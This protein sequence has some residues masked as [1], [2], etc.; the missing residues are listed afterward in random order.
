MSFSKKQLNKNPKD[1]SS[2]TPAHV[3]AIFIQKCNERYENGN[4]IITDYVYDQMFQVFKEKNPEH[5]LLKKI[6]AEPEHDKVTL[7]IHMGSMDKKLNKKS[8]DLW[9]QKYPGPEYIVSSKLDG[10]SGLLV[11]S[12]SKINLYSRGNGTIGRN[13]N[14]LIPYFN[15]PRVPK[16]YIIRGELI[17]SKSDKLDSYTN[18]RSMATA[19]MGK[20]NPGEEAK[21]IKFVCY[22]L[23]SYEG[24]FLKVNIEGQ[25]KVLTRLGFDVVKHKKIDNII[26]PE[27]MEDSTLSKM[28]MEYRLETEYDIDGIIITENKIHS[29]NTS[30]NPDY[31]FAFKSNGMGE[32]TTVKNVDWNISKHGYLIPRINVEQVTIDGTKIQFATAFNAKYVYTNKIGPET[33]V[34]IIRSGDVIPYVIEIIESTHAQMPDIEYSWTKSGVNAIAIGESKELTLKKITSFIKTLGIPFLSKGLIKKLY[35][36]GI[37]TLKDVLDI[38]PEILL[39]FDGIQSTMAHKLYKAIH[40]VIDNPILLEKVMTASLV[41]G[42]GF[43]EKKIKSI[44][45]V[46]PNLLEMD[47]LDIDALLLVPGIS[48]ITGEAFLRHL[49]DFK[50]WLKQYP[51][52][53]TKIEIAKQESSG[54]YKDKIIVFSGFR[55]EEMEQKIEMM[56][57]KIGSQINKKTSML[58]VKSRDS[59]SS[60]VSAAELLGIPIVTIDEL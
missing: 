45:N 49:G 15:L 59:T 1:Y 20:K 35:E 6:G 4:P 36:N 40:D 23:H 42:H 56:G 51:Q 29:M 34:R 3:L 58:V 22:N 37:N 17:V 18:A 11:K 8:I 7:P 5:P 27:K 41:F 12:G 47:D 24:K 33:K 28:L 9:L 2:K 16:D 55:N 46:Y 43:G 21:L 19:I 31:A 39:A 10:A 54:K 60:K 48:S 25:L 50:E 57:G 44:I 38:T 26:V 14:H 13:L 32:V 52:I 53:K 30:G